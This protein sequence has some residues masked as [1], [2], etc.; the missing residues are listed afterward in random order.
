MAKKQGIALAVL[1][2]VLYIIG[3]VSTFAGLGLILFMH[4]RD[5][6]GLGDGSSMGYLFL[7]VG[8]SLSILGILLM[9]IFKNR[10][11]A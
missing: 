1:A 2:L 8:L 10:G 6:F 5:L 4:G 3:G 7:C 11:L 9:R